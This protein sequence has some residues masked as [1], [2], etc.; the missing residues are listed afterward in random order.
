MHLPQRW[1]PVFANRLFLGIATLLMVINLSPI[2]LHTYPAMTDYPNHLARMAIIDQLDESPLLQQFYAKNERLCPNMGMDVIVPLLHKFGL[3]LEDAIRIFLV[4]TLVFIVSGAIAL[5]YLLQGVTPWFT[6]SIFGFLYSRYFLYGFLNYFFAL[7]VALVATCAWIRLRSW[8]AVARIVFFSAV[9]SLLLTLHLVA[10]GIYAFFVG[11]I[12]LHRAIKLQAWKRVETYVV[13]MQF[14]LPVALYATQFEHSGKPLIFSELYPSVSGVFTSKVAGLVGIFSSYDVQSGVA[15]AIFTL[16]ALLWTLKWRQVT[17]LAEFWIPAAIFTAVFLCLPN[18]LMGSAYLDRR[19]SIAAVFFLI[20]LL[21]LRPGPHIVVIFV[22]SLTAL[23]CVRINEINSRWTQS[24]NIFS[25]YRAE[26]QKVPY[27]A[28][29]F[30]YMTVKDHHMEFPPVRHIDGF[31]VVDRSAF[32]GNIFAMP[33]VCES[34][35]VQPNLSHLQR[36]NTVYPAGLIPDWS[37]VVA[38]F[39]NVVI[40]YEGEKPAYPE[41][42]KVISENGKFILL[43]N[44]FLKTSTIALK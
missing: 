19:I 1:H 18:E 28:K 33:A 17:P 42:F 31:A 13:G 6:L 44:S 43:E 8:P 15:I 16:G 37:S 29:L 32:I 22:L 9:A 4:L 12:E 23:V 21:R 14:A 36:I 39:N 24:E 10:F 40:I 5:G 38:N 27:G 7:G 2:L 30:I 11:G 35:H 20:P 34:V 41:G 25:A 3:S 26:L